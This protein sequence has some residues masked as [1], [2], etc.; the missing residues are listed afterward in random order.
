[1]E[2]LARQF[3]RAMRAHQLY[4]PNNPMYQRATDAVRGAFVPLW[5]VT[6]EVVLDVTES[7]FRWEG[8]VVAQET[9]KAESLPWVFYKDG[10]RQLT[11]R[12]G[13]E[14]QELGVLLT[15]LRRARHA[16]AQEDDLLTLLWEQDFVY[17]TYRYV[18]LAPDGAAA[19]ERSPHAAPE[20]AAERHAPVE[21]SEEPQPGLIKLDDF[22]ATLYFLDEKEIEYLR[23]E[24]STEYRL[25]PRANAL[26]ILFDIF[27]VQATDEVRGEVVAI[28]EALI[29]H[30][31]AANELSVVAMV[32]REVR[33][34]TERVEGLPSTLRATLEGLSER[35]STPGVLTQLLRALDESEEV[36]QEEDLNALFEQLRPGTLGIVL[37]WLGQAQNARVRAALERAA[38]RLAS[39]NTAEL[40]T[41]IGSAD[42]SL[43][44]EAMR[45]SGELQSSAAVGA[46][47]K[48][49]GQ[50]DPALRLAAA[51]ALSA[52]G[53][54]GALQLLEQA[55]RDADRDVRVTAVRAVAARTYYA[56]LPKIEAIVRGKGLR[57]ADLTEKM[58]VFEAY[59]V[60][61]GP[62][63]VA[64]LDAL[65]NGRSLF[66]RRQDSEVRACAATAL[67]R[68]GHEGALDALRRSSGD[69]D[70]IVR[71]A[72]NRALRGEST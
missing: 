47:G 40:V 7:E 8:R 36:P 17:L 22:D 52:I 18:D 55:L 54:T 42:P 61:A 56:A 41:L 25:D 69:K 15:V 4:L 72:V 3:G 11:L 29:P 60:L 5:T 34:L 6:D 71:N 44:R 35:L 10:I 64:V 24:V 58:A 70:V 50:A 51:Q 23:S 13:V 67:G 66:A 62:A 45:R 65:L 31:L 30:L 59:G 49:L 32:L 38:G 68:I 46:L 33:T 39:A 53:S 2:E 12:R 16:T 1:V 21:A 28:L 57:E 48:I 26:A 9:S 63:G 37:S 43:C 14:E 20:H 19:L 27:E